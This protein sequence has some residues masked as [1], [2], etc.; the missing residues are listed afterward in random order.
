MS[1]V[2]FIG[3]QNSAGEMRVKIG[4]TTRNPLARLL[5]FQ[6]GSPEEL[7]ILSYID[8]DMALERKLH[9]T[10]ATVR[11]HNEWFLATGCLGLLVSR[12]MNEG[13]GARRVTP[14]NVFLTAMYDEVYRA[15]LYADDEAWAELAISADASMWDHDFSGL[16][17]E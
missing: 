13:G 12:L 17:V 15:R 1:F 10:F 14:T 2:Y 11:L 16:L 3:C 9:Q 6:P 8:G 5:D 4:F 7:D